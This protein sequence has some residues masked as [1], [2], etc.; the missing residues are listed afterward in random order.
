[1]T[2]QQPAV[3]PTP[4]YQQGGP[5]PLWAPLYGASLVDAIR[6][7]FSKYA[8]FSGRAS[9]SEYWWWVLVDFVVGIVFSILGG[10]LG[11]AGSST[12]DGATALGPGFVVVGILGTLWGLVTVVPH[13]AL[14]WRRLHDANFAGP[15]WFLSFV[16]FGSL[17][18]LVFTVLPSN[19]L[20]SRFDRPHA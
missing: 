15:W 18:V 16:P 8:D 6:R 12:S 1:M 9:R 14:I 17:V 13:L 5:T 20:G 10:V 4:P 7:F 3:P 2:Y 11:F 19:P